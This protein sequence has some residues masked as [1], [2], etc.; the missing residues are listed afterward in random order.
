MKLL[1]IVVSYKVTDLTID[2]LRSLSGEIHR[3]PGARVAVCENGTGGDAEARLRQAIE[4]NGWGSWVDL[5]VVYPNR[6]FTGGNNAIIRQAMASADP[7]EYFL[8]LN[9]DTIVHLHAL[10]SLVD[11]MDR[12]PKVGIAGSRLES[13]DGKVQASP[14]RFFS[15]ASEFDR[16]LRLGL[17]SKLLSRWSSCPPNPQRQCEVEWVSGASMII[18]RQVVEEIGPLDEGLYTYFDD[19]DYCWNA[20]RARWATW[21]VPQSRVTH[22]EG[23]STGITSR[24]IKRRPSYWF[25][26]RRRFYLKNRGPFYTMMADAAF[27]V[28]FALWRV[29]RWL[30]RKPDNDPPM[31]LRDFICNSLFCTGFKLKAVENPA[32]TGTNSPDRIE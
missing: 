20:Q 27:I 13:P 25:Q 12:N 1:V 28:G 31:M 3:V 15:I 21:Y 10:D 14:F 8:L 29:R 23:A 32:M 18:R 17:V 7:P 5:T 22:L 6:G 30:Q 9:A 26:A 4:E 2:C 24:I 16:G 11:F 19:I